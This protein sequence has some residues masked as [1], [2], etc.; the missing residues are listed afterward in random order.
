MHVLKI[1]RFRLEGMMHVKYFTHH[2]KVSLTGG[3]SQGQEEAAC[4]HPANITTGMLF[5]GTN[6]M[7]F[8][9]AVTWSS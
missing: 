5:I 6:D 1:R 9:R 3:E 4:A 2:A 7:K 8:A